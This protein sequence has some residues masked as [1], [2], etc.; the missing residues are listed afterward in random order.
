MISFQQELLYMVI[1]EVD[2]LL[3]LHYEELTQNKDRIKLDPRWDEYA[4][5]ERIGQLM[6]YTSRADGAL[7]G[8]AA[9]FL[10]RH[11][12]YAGWLAAINDVIFLHPEHRKGSTGVRLIR[13]CEAQ[14]KAAG[15]HELVF[16]VK[17]GT[18]ME[19]LITAMGYG[20]KETTRGKIL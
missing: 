19:K 13:F 2:A 15:A 20:L 3:K 16:H 14:A 10:N 11:L 1:D 4:A 7:I 17:P 6:V 8:Y 9:F 12:H 5:L 18:V